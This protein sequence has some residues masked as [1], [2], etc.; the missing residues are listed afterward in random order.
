MSRTISFATWSPAFA[1]SYTVCAV[2]DSS[3]PPTIVGIIDALSSR[4]STSRARV[5]IAGPEA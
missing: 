4:T 1:A 2:I 3:F 5:A